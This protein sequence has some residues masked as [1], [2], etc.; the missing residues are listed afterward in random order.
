VTEGVEDRVM[1]PLTVVDEDPVPVFVA[2]NDGVLDA[3]CVGVRNGDG[4]PVATLEPDLVTVE[5]RV[6]VELRVLDRVPV[7]DALPVD[8]IDPVPVPDS[9]A[10]K[11]PV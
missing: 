4:V 10:V 8:D 7:L 2:L 3:V 9:V 5:V 11:D 1:D 6:C